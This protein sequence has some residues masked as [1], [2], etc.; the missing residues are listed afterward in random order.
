[1]IQA[2]ASCAPRSETCPPKK[3]PRF[4]VRR[5]GAIALV[6]AACALLG[7]GGYYAWQTWF[8]QDSGR[9]GARHGGG[10]SAATSRTR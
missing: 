1:M 5:F 9:R 4:A 10:D 3:K 6:V 8:G 2:R 7:A